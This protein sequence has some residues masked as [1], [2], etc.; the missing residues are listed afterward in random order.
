MVRAELG[1]YLL[2]L[3]LKQWILSN[4][5][6][7]FRK[8]YYLFWSDKIRQT[9]ESLTYYMYKNDIIT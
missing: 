4:M 2:K 8:D 9:S 7:T 5:E 6:D 1:R 3:T